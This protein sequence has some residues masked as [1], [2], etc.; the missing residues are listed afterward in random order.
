MKI[1]TKFNVGD[2]VYVCKNNSTYEKEPCKIC[3]GTGMI[4]FK[5]TTFCCP[6]CHTSKFT[7]SKKVIKFTPEERTIS[8]VI[9]SESINN[10]NL[11]I[12]TRYETKP[13]CH[14]IAEHENMIFTTKEEAEERCKELNQREV[15]EN[16]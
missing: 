15:R 1:E 13:H 6:Q 14:R 9:V 5:G 10:G 8:K 16:E 11:Q 4:T 7:H 2:V 12:Y 3:E